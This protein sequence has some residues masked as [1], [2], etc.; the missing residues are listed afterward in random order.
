MQ[1]RHQVIVVD[2]V[3]GSLEPESRVLGDIAD[4]KAVSAT[5]EDDLAGK[6]EDADALMLYHTMSLTRRTIE[7]LRRCKLIVRCGVGYDNVDHVF[8]RKCGIAVANVPDY[9]TEEVADSA[10]GMALTLMRGIGFL[11]ARLRDCRGPWSWREVVPLHRL[12]GRVF[13][14]VGLGRIGT[15]VAIRAKA[16]GMDVAFHDPYKPDGFDKALGIRRVETLTELLAQAYILSLHCPL[17]SETTRLIGAAALESM[18]HGSFLVNSARGA[19]V[20]TAAIAPAIACGRLAGAAIDVLPQEPPAE[21]D[22]LVRAWRD[23]DH[24]AHDRVVLNPHTAFYSEEGL[25]DMRVKG[26]E[27]CRRA[28]EGLP[29]RNVVN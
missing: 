25:L 7:R 27:A 5:N 18:P 26:A 12:R 1:H 19:V 13:A 8:A 16:L 14:I 4:V 28:L 23:P 6:V 9:G 21:D 15:A 29:L 20:D 22:P 11:N 3:T 17:T 24:P 2:L 10:V